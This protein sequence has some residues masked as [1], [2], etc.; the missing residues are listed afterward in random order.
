MN[1]TLFGFVQ[2]WDTPPIYEHILISAVVKTWVASGL[3]LPR[4]GVGRW[5]L[6]NWAVQFSHVPPLQI[7]EYVT[8]FGLPL[9]LSSDLCFDVDWPCG[10]FWGSVVRPRGRFSSFGETSVPWHVASHMTS[11]TVTYL[12]DQGVDW[13]PLF[14]CMPLALPQVLTPWQMVEVWCQHLSGGTQ[15]LMAWCVSLHCFEKN[16]E[17]LMYGLMSLAF[18]NAVNCQWLQPLPCTTWVMGVY[19]SHG[20]VLAYQRALVHH[21]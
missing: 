8:P 12:R 21:L 5:P 7:I 19:L 17:D 4:S 9:P 13:R 3:R 2:D 14:A 18:S 6:S 15:A 16:E 20:C 11:Q 1:F 10:L